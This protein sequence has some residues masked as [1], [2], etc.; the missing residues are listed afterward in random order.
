MEGQLTANRTK[1][2]AWLLLCFAALS[3]TTQAKDAGPGR[4]VRQVRGA[5]QTLIPGATI[6]NVVVDHSTGRA[7]V[8][9]TRTNGTRG[10]DGFAYVYDRWW[11][12]LHFRNDGA[13]WCGN[14]APPFATGIYGKKQPVAIGDLITAGVPRAL[15]AEAVTEFDGFNAA[16]A[17][18]AQALLPPSLVSC[19]NGQP[20]TMSGSNQPQLHAAPWQAD[21][22]AIQ[23]RMPA[24]MPVLSAAK[25]TGRRPNGAE[26]WTYYP[27]GNAY[28]YFD[29]ITDG[30]TPV[31][32]PSGTSVDIW[33][34]FALDTNKTYSLTLAKAAESVGPIN[35]KLQNNILHFDLPAFTIPAH[36]TLIGEVDGTM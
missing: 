23:I 27:G 3:S 31:D 26:N 24:Q 5:A 34:P 33:F 4:D 12:L 6:A 20:G 29:V 1:F 18:F 21:G 10:I 35:G 19:S 9:W 2:S 16:S 7:L 13:G 28:V 8:Q 36:A 14:A 11:D 32:L 15:A 22:Y 17:Q 30:E 25:L